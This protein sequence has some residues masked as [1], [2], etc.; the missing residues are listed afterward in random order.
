MSKYL[1]PKAARICLFLVFFLVCILQQQIFA[2]NI[3]KGRVIEYE[4][5]VPIP[6]ASVFLPNTTLGITADE[7]GNFSLEIPD[8]N[9]E[10]LVRMLGFKS[11]T[12]SIKTESLPAKGYQVQLESDE[13]ELDIID[14]EEERDPVW[15]HNLETFKRFF[16]GTSINGQAIEILNE[17]DLLIDNETVP[18]LLQVDA[19][20]PIILENPNLGYQIEYLLTEFKYNPKE[21]TVFYGGF[22][23]FTAYQDLSAGKEKRIVKKREIAYHGSIQ[24]FLHSLYLGISQEEGY[25]I[26]RLKRIPNPNKPS[27]AEFEAARNLY[28]STRSQAVKDSIESNVFS[29]SN[30]A[31]QLEILD[32]N[33]L[34]P[35]EILI[36]DQNGKVFMKFEDLIHIT[37]KNE[38]M[39]REYPGAP[40]ENLKKTNQ[41]SKAFLTNEQIELFFN[42]SYMDPFGLMV[43]E[44]MAWEKVGD[45]M[46]L[47]YTPIISEK[48]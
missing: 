33:E 2:Q 21:G 7:N 29:K 12:F 31:D 30:L 6:F 13:Q 25:L 20:N 32:Q 5:E 8:G 15:Y 22:P 40:F 34:E 19:R 41:V 28:R 4:T 39:A 11:A 48:K 37:Y 3:L 43:E 36:R 24:H 1:R 44:Y 16:L 17:K 38:P 23:L 14:V 27:P 18:G 35:E 46:P 45:L 26:R 9:Y 10:V 42:G 47:D